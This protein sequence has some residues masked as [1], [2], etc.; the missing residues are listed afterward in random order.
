MHLMLVLSIIGE[1]ILTLF[2]VWLTRRALRS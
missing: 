2:F 1:A